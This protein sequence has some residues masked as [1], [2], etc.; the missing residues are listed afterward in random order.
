MLRHSFG[1]RAGTALFAAALLLAASACQ[2]STAATGPT[3]RRDGAVHAYR[4]P[5]G[6]W[7]M[8]RPSDLGQ[9]VL[10]VDHI[11]IRHAQAEPRAAPLSPG[12]WLNQEPPPERSRGDAY[13]R[14]LAIAAELRAQPGSFAEVARRR[15]ED[16]VTAERGGSLGGLAASDLLPWPNLLDAL[17]QLRPG[18]ISEVLETPF[19]FHI[20]RRRPPPVEAR[21]SGRRV[22]VGYD[23]ASFLDYARRGPL[24]HRSRAQARA[25]A[26]QIADEARRHPDRFPD[27]VRAR[28][29]HVDAAQGGDL[30]EWS[31]RE[32]SPY[33]RELELLNAGTEGEIT[34][35]I[36]TR[37]G[38]VVLQRTALMERARYAMTSVRLSFEP[39]A[40]PSSS[41]ARER[42][43]ELA[44]S[45][46]A[47][48]QSHPERMP[49]FQKTYCCRDLET[50]TEGRG[51]PGLTD[52]LKALSVG[53]IANEPV[54]SYWNFI[55][56]RREPPRPPSSPATE[57]P[58][59]ASP[60]LRYLVEVGSEATLEALTRDLEAQGQ[61]RL[62]LSGRDLESYTRLH[63]ALRGEL[64]RADEPALRVRELDKMMDALRAQLGTARFE[65]YRAAVSAA[66]EREILEGGG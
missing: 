19:G 10:W 3:S 61:Q 25:L 40:P 58:A 35:P 26:Q 7:R 41:L 56:P 15:S 9:V 28:S 48:L 17:A 62:A 50:W 21:V 14:A 34:S 52:A 13:A 60:D 55:I 36:D 2:R 43:L 1:E 33:A 64:I 65:K 51:A 29:E 57:L 46:A 20:L 37:F 8:A 45:V 11:L 59:P 38:F 63:Q 66:I 27:L 54:E 32:G 39:D 18:E 47:T 42:V 24:I 4:Y 5:R 49:E 31:T 30:G 23:G 12:G 44:R 22:V 53:E 16:P 6:R